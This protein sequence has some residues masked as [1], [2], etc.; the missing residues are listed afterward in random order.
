MDDKL[1]KYI[2]LKQLLTTIEQRGT[3]EDH[4]YIFHIIKKYTNQYTEN[5]NGVFIDI[6]MLTEDAIQ[7]I[8]VYLKNKCISSK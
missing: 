3:D 4:S 6:S 5:Q 8:E 2:H 7:E 1:Q